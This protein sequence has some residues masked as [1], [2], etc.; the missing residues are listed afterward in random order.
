MII[1]ERTLK[2]V[3]KAIEKAHRQSRDYPE[4]A[5]IAL[6]AFARHA[7]PNDLD[8]FQLE[9]CDSPCAEYD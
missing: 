8:S 9:A 1:R 5:E 4:I 7:S 3:G 6:K 2:V